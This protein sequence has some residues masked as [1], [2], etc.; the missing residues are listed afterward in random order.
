[1]PT[2]RLCFAPGIVDHDGAVALV[3]QLADAQV[4]PARVQFCGVELGALVE[5]DVGGQRVGEPV[6][7]LLDLEEARLGAARQLLGV[8]PHLV[9]R[10]RGPQL[11]HTRTSPS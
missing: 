2:P 6:R 7:P 5:V 4:D 8:H 11:R 1:M 10:M 3:H 9:G